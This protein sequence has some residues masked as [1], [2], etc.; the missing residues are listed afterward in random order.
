MYPPGSRCQGCS[1]R[2]R[3][4]V[5]LLP[6]LHVIRLGEA[7]PLLAR[8]TLRLLLHLAPLFHH[9]LR[10]HDQQ[11][12]QRVVAGDA[13]LP[14]VA[15]QHQSSLSM[16]FSPLVW[17]PATPVTAV[18]ACIPITLSREPILRMSSR[19]R[20]LA[21]DQPVPE[22]LKI[23]LYRPDDPFLLCQAVTYPSQGRGGHFCRHLTVHIPV[24]SDYTII[25]P[26]TEM[27]LGS[28]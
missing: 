1:E 24:S 18:L 27:P 14:E 3:L 20:R 13:C 10:L 16:C 9:P 6:P 15:V 2:R 28:L 22:R 19:R 8:G 26:K 11:P 17:S 23:T 25:S 12:S 5:H 4:R 21:G 7:A